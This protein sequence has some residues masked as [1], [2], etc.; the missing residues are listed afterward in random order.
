MSGEHAGEARSTLVELSDE[1]IGFL[2]ESLDYSAKAF[3]EYSYDGQ[4]PVWVA[5]HRRERSEMISSIR[6]ALSNPRR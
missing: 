5:Q 3:R 2:R 4:D 1:Q 6:E